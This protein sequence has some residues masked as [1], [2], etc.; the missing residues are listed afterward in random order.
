MT[1]TLE[2][3]VRNPTTQTTYLLTYL[4]MGNVN[5]RTCEL[6]DGYSCTAVTSDVNENLTCKLE[7][8][9]YHDQMSPHASI[10]F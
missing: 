1:Q 8:N 9:D 2:T 6:H 3:S 7:V 4:L 5:A 10:G